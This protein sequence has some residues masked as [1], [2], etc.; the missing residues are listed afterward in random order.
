MGSRGG[1]AE[2]IDGPDN[3]NLRVWW[4][5]AKKAGVTSHHHTPVPVRSMHAP[6]HPDER[7]LNTLQTCPGGGCVCRWSGGTIIT[8]LARRR[9][10]FPGPPPPPLLSYSCPHPHIPSSSYPGSV[11][12]R[13]SHTCSHLP[14]LPL[15]HYLFNRR[16]SHGQSSGWWVE[17][18]C[19][20]SAPYKRPRLGFTRTNPLLGLCRCGP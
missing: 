4:W 7:T 3:I 16:A 2:E 19:S 6:S 20:S 5:L 14:P 1:R 8:R 13:H 9:T 17:W 12:L 15:Y 10:K 18:H 11:T